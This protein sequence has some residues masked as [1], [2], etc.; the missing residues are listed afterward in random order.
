MYPFFAILVLVSTTTLPE[1]L[2]V[3]ALHKIVVIYISLRICK[4]NWLVISTSMTLMV[5]GFTMVFTVRASKLWVLVGHLPPIPL[6]DTVRSGGQFRKIAPR[7]S[8]VPA[9]GQWIQI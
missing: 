1:I 9:R 3:R 7:P 2:Y 8:N 4:K 5:R 6:K